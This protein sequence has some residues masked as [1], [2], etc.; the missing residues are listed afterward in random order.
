MVFN[1][2]SSLINW[3]TFRIG[4]KFL[5]KLGHSVSA[6]ELIFVLIKRFVKLLVLGSFVLFISKA[7]ASGIK[8]PISTSLVSTTPIYSTANGARI[9]EVATSSK[10]NE[11][12]REGNR[13]RVQFL[14]P[15]VKGWVSKDYVSEATSSSGRVVKV[16]VDVLNFRTQPSVGSSRISQLYLGYASP[17]L[18][19]ENGFVQ[20]YAPASL[21]VLIPF[22]GSTS[23]PLMTDGGQSRDVVTPSEELDK[24]TASSEELAHLIAPGDSLSLVVYGEPDLSIT[25]TR[26]DSNGEAVF[27]LLGSISVAGRTTRQ[28]T[29]DIVD[30]LSKGYVRNPRA[31]VSIAS[32]R[33]VFVRGEIS[34]GT[35]DYT[36]G[37]TLTQVIS[38]AG[39]LIS[40]S[41]A[42]GISII[43]NGQTIASGLTSSSEFKILSGDIVDVDADDVAKEAEKSFIYLHG[44]VQ[45]VGEYLYRPG[46]TVE[47]AVVLAGGFSIRASKRKV[48]ITRY[49]EL[50]EGAEPVVLEKVKLYETIK[51]GDVIQVGASWF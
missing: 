8:D 42:D 49:F 28:V 44:E 7:Y 48:R 24:Q 20:V 45:N 32:Y 47:K 27:P 13:V 11:V 33:P 14:R 37:L 46:L 15:T 36:E 2:M 50:D 6:V 30:S 9:G 26:V 21:E 3:L 18:G 16:S 23:G 39:G 29:Q 25:G 51:P 17:V 35:I 43:R 1:S 34:Q 12:R 5:G 31:L 41:K 38:L 19:E 40:T 10:Y 22:T 4:I